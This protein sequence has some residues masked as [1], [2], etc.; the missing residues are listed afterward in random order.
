[1]TFAQRSQPPIIKNTRIKGFWWCGG[2]TLHVVTTRYPYY[3]LKLLEKLRV[4]ERARKCRVVKMFIIVWKSNWKLLVCIRNTCMNL[5]SSLSIHN[6]QTLEI[7]L[8]SEKLMIG[9]W[10]LLFAK[11]ITYMQLSIMALSLLTSQAVP[12]WKTSGEIAVEFIFF[13]CPF[14]LGSLYAM[15]NFAEI[16]WPKKVG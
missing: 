1:M 8:L 3:Y 12:F 6:Y 16:N 10:W 15:I 13:L 9:R 5:E 11:V 4:I 7:L 2:T 14:G